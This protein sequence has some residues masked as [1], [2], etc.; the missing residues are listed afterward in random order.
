MKRALL[1]TLILACLAAPSAWGETRGHREA[2]AALLD[3]MKE[4]QDL[5]GVVGP[6]VEAQIRA[7][8]QIEPFR[9]I[10][11]DWT[12]RYFNWDAIGPQMI[13]LYMRTFTESELRDLVAFYRTPTGRKALEKMPAL[14]QEGVKI[15]ESIAQQHSGELENMIKARTRELERAQPNGG[16]GVS[17]ADEV[18]QGWL[19][20]AGQFYDQGKWEDAKNAYLRYLEESPDDVGAVAELGVCYKELGDYDRALRNFDRALVLDPG[21]WQALYNKI[22]VL[23]FNVGKKAEAKK[24]MREL[25]RQ[26]PTNPEVARLAQ[27]VAQL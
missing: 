16:R 23:G 17:A 9:D 1:S 6:L 2:A 14:M 26:Q 7:N 20:R 24:L 25:R 11:L 19:A 15:G 10:L 21:H 4:A 8:P 3:V 13:D 18:A 27:Q 12:A 22:I 5:A